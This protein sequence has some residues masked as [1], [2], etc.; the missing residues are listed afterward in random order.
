MTDCKVCPIAII[1][2]FGDIGCPILKDWLTHQ[3]Y[4]NGK[5]KLDSCPKEKK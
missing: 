5:I 2:I 4:R 1:N 3:E